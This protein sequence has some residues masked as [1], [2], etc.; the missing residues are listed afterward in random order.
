[1]AGTLACCLYWFH[2]LAWWAAAQQRKESEMACDDQVLMGCSSDSYADG[3]VAV[4]GRGFGV[5]GRIGPGFGIAG[6]SAAGGM[7]G[8]G[9]GDEGR[10]GVYV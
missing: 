7:A 2:P 5:A 8:R 4:A 10:V 1:M 6:G 9:R 3:L